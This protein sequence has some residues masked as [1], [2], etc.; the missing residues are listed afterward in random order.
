MKLVTPEKIYAQRISAGKEQAEADFT[1][2]DLQQ[3]FI[4][5]HYTQLYHTEAYALLND[6]QRLRYNQLYGMR[7]NEQFMLFESGFTN[8]VM[9]SLLARY[10]RQDLG[11]LGQCLDI[12]LQ[13]E[14]RHYHM[15]YRLNQLSLPGVYSRQTH[16]FLQISRLQQ[17]ILGFV[18]RF[19]RQ[20]PSLIWLVLL[21]EEHAVCFSRDMLKMPASENLGELESNYLLAH[22]L[23]L[24]DEVG[25]VHIDANIIDYV[26]QDSSMR[27]KKLNARLLRN[28]LH[29]TLKPRHAGINVIRQLVSE[30]PQL[31]SIKRQLENCIRTLDIDPCLA[32][33]LKDC[34]KR[35]L[36]TALM[37]IYPEFQRALAD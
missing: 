21:M 18:C 15:F 13:E 4:H 10:D 8:R 5:E 1:P 33:L 12:L 34:S 2:I 28:L 19:P 20:L 30:F 26:L 25:H 23:H 17:W 9:S 31:R 11:A 27:N 7:T 16:H 35:P 3:P 6:A 37:E 14:Q 22:R 36:T 24:Q 32:P 29:A